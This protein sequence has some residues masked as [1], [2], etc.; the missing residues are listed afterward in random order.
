MEIPHAFNSFFPL[1]KGS[2]LSFI[3]E[4]QD[5]GTHVYLLEIELGIGVFVGGRTLTNLLPI[6]SSIC[7]I[8]HWFFKTYLY[9]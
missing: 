1:T 7:N 4:F 6:N 3:S 9:V 8:V 5:L 2:Y